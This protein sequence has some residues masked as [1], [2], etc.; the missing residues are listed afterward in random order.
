MKSRI[1][2]GPASDTSY[3]L[4]FFVFKIQK[5]FVHPFLKYQ[6]KKTNECFK[7]LVSAG[8]DYRKG[9]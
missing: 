8:R 3:L 4:S 2:Q 6:F 5:A 1:T 7:G 9:L